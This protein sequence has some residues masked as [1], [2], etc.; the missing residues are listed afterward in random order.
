MSYSPIRRLTAAALCCSGL[1]TLAAQSQ[2]A[3]DAE[4]PEDPGFDTTVPQSIVDE[5]VVV[6]GRSRAFLRDQIQIA[7][8][9]MYARFNEINSDDKF[10]ISCQLEPI[11][12][13]RMLRRVCVG[14]YWRDADA[15]IGEQTARA[16]Q[17]FTG[18]HPMEYRTQ[19]HENTRLMLDEMRQL[20]VEDEEFRNTLVRL[21]NLQNLLREGNGRRSRPTNTASRELT[22]DDGPLPYDADLVFEVRIGRKDWEHELTRRTFTIAQVYGEIRSVDVECDQGRERLPYEPEAE[23][24]LPESWSSCTVVVDAA[25]DTSFAL[26]EFE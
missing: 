15:D 4:A 16:F 22:V 26:Y 3:S 7:E 17:G 19:Q 21:A 13:S 14:N 25:R 18:V 12:N 10:D 24:S 1:M 2:E 20:A 9:A 8:E 6:Q 23:F 5:I 11:N